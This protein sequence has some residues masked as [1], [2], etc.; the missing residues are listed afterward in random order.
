[1]KNTELVVAI[2]SLLLDPKH[3]MDKLKSLAKAYAEACT[4]L[5]DGIVHCITVLRSGNSVDA[6]RLAHAEHILEDYD[7]LILDFKNRELWLEAVKTLTEI[8]IPTVS[9]DLADELDICEKQVEDQKDILKRHRLLAYSNGPMFNRIQVL[10]RLVARNPKFFEWQKDL[11]TYIQCYYDQLSDQ[12]TK[13]T[14][15]S[16][17]TEIED[18]VAKVSQ[19][20]NEIPTLDAKP[21]AT[22][23]RAILTRKDKLTR[24]DIQRRQ[25]LIFGDL[26]KVTA[27]LVNSFQHQHLPSGEEAMACWEMCVE[28]LKKLNANPPQAMLEKTAEPIRWVRNEQFVRAATDEYKIQCRI[29][30]RNV[31]VS[32]TP[33]SIVQKNF[34][35]LCAAANDAGIT[36]PNNIT[37]AMRRREKQSERRLF[38]KKM[39]SILLVLFILTGLGTGTYFGVQYWL[40]QKLVTNIV[41]KLEHLKHQAEVDS[42]YEEAMKYVNK[43]EKEYV[44]EK[45]LASIQNLL[46]KIKHDDRKNQERQQ[47]FSALADTLRGEIVKK[48]STDPNLKEKLSNLQKL[49]RSSDEKSLYE[50]LATKYEENKKN[51]IALRDKKF[52][53]ETNSLF[54][55][56]KQLKTDSEDAPKHLSKLDAK[57]KDLEEW[58]EEI[59]ESVKKQEIKSLTEAIAQKKEACNSYQKNVD[60]QT[61]YEKE[62]KNLINNSNDIDSYISSLEKYLDFVEN[63]PNDESDIN[64]EEIENRLNTDKKLW[65][66][67]QKWNKFMETNGSVMN[68]E[69][70][71]PEFADNF[72]KEWDESIMVDKDQEWNQALLKKISILKKKKSGNTSIKD[73]IEELLSFCNGMSIRDYW[74]AQK[75]KNPNWYYFVEN[76]YDVKTRYVVSWDDVSGEAAPG[77]PIYDSD[78]KKSPHVR[79]CKQLVK[80]TE[81]LEKN[82]EENA[83]LILEKIL[84]TY[85]DGKEGTGNQLDPLMTWYLLET[86]VDKLRASNEDFQKAY[87]PLWKQCCKYD[88]LS[89]RVIELPKPSERTRI[90]RD[91][92]IR[93]LESIQEGRILQKCEN[94]F[95]SQNKINSE[96]CAGIY[97]MVGFATWERNHIVIHKI[98]PNTSLS[99]PLWVCRENSDLDTEIEFLTFGNIR[100]GVIT[101]NTN[102]LG[103][104]FQY[105]PVFVFEY[106]K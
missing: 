6:I 103:E 51:M 100:N 92:A 57:V 21:P 90:H 81:N 99:G 80:I 27:Q 3:K 29:F 44:K 66:S 61:K 9:E 67:I 77:T 26:K 71:T 83:P 69:T 30:E 82:F 7:T 75:G 101:P 68:S 34:L 48:Q 85:A 4:T 23:V 102:L 12:V 8:N 50:E 94:A 5:N 52:K 49:Q 96:K 11:E 19:I 43:I 32:T 73:N 38:R 106:V 97:R 64:A 13:V 56:I 70:I 74:Y 63:N 20:S 15:L 84:Q 62:F 41:S 36:I 72:L 2:E 47:E 35:K 89:G 1:M 105:A 22:L 95:L 14:N 59:T 58:P 78:R 87:E 55:Q 46:V 60:L 40:Q 24:E 45:D 28:K 10:R 91:K 65:E 31:G 17:I 25:N 98:L 79:L 88:D 39:C 86:F 54:D 16:G 104:K 18:E 76:G 37:E 33:L 93:I 53:E 42:D